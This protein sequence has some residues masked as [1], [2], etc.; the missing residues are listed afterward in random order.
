MEI[1]SNVGSSIVGDVAMEGDV[2]KEDKPF[3]S[4]AM[5]DTTSL[6]VSLPE[7]ILNSCMMSTRELYEKKS[8]E[9]SMPCKQLSLDSLLTLLWKPLWP[10]KSTEIFS[11]DHNSRLDSFALYL[12]H[13]SAYYDM[14]TACI[15][16]FNVIS[17]H[18]LLLD[19]MR[20]SIAKLLMMMTATRRQSQE[21]SIMW[22]P[23]VLYCPHHGGN[24][25]H[26]G[27]QL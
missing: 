8:M 22:K 26:H 19:K 13:F 9:S 1:A 7:L 17:M 6:L 4:G 23:L 5:V 27:L 21:V 3:I 18:E 10:T 2:A 12:P 25:R 14:E 24:L 15:H 20:C 11:M 16:S